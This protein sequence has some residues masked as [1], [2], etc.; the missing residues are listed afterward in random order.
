MKTYKYVKSFKEIQAPHPVDNNTARL[1][2]QQTVAGATVAATDAV[3]V[4]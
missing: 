4:Q 2:E 3:T 1:G